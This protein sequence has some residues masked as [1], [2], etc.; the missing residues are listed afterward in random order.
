[1]IVNDKFYIILFFV[2]INLFLYLLKDSVYRKFLPTDKPSGRKIHSK[3]ITING[4]LFF[5][6]N[7]IFIIF[8][9]NFTDEIFENFD[10]IKFGYLVSIIVFFLLGILDD[11]INLN[12]TL[13]LVLIVIIL[14]FFLSENNRFLI[15]QLSFH[16]IEYKIYLGNYSIFFTILCLSLFI[17]SF[18]MFD[19]I[20]LQSGFYSLTFFIFF[21]LNGYNILFCSIL[22]F[23]H[24]VFL[25]KNYK[26]ESFL[27]DGGC[28]I[29]SFTIGL[30]IINFYNQG[31]I[32]SDQIFLLML[33]PG[34]DMLRLF[35]IR[36]YNRKNPFSGDR[37]H[38][39]HFLLKKFGDLKTFIIIYFVNLINFVSV[40]LNLNTIIT[41]IFSLSV[42]FVLIFKKKIK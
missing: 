40:G 17:N 19:G 35:I 12:G 26:D 20:N 4:G 28:Y 33:I 14:Y 10:Q 3:P 6:I 37:N 18:N 42:Y 31:G 25:L 1:M 32:K 34:V 16:L 8:F 27:G 23:T 29:L 9:S 7:L 11:K 2:F 21:L 13:K 22:V 41:L 15:S 38:L 24:I 39:H 5:F 30:F 36:I